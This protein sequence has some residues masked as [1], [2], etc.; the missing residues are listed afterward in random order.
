MEQAALLPFKRMGLSGLF[1]MFGL[2]LFGSQYSV[3]SAAFK[4]AV[5]IQWNTMALV[6]KAWEKL[7][8][9]ESGVGKLLEKVDTIRDLASDHI[10]GRMGVKVLGLFEDMN[11]ADVEA[12][13]R[14]V[15]G[16]LGVRAT[17]FEPA[18]ALAHPLN[19]LS[20]A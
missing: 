1:S 9:G 13:K 3:A 10:D 2:Q 12:L 4:F 20:H 8:E 16:F 6:S 11:S 15:A 7:K 18:H 14:G 5:S 19:P 17:A